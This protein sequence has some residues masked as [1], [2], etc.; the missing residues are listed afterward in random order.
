M[1]MSLSESAC[2]EGEASED[3]W[4]TR[5]PACESAVAPPPTSRIGSSCT[6]SFSKAPRLV[7]SYS[8]CLNAISKMWGSDS[9]S[10]SFGH[11]S[12]EIT[13]WNVI[14]TFDWNCLLH[15]VAWEKWATISLKT[16][17]HTHKKIQNKTSAITCR[18]LS[19][20]LSISFLTWV[21]NNILRAASAFYSLCGLAANRLRLQRPGIS[22]LISLLI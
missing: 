13:Y 10:L 16:Q 21:I 6:S 7:R 2:N 3:H 15:V 20:Y 22:P 18:E 1:E 5:L 19:I 9:A 4:M 8:D 17:K 14:L 12:T 11:Y